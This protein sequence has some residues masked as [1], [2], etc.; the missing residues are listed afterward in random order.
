MGVV[1]RVRRG[2]RWREVEVEVKVDGGVVL[3]V[4]GERDGVRG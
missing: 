1:V 2:L 3:G 4:S